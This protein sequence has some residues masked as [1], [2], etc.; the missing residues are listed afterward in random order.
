LQEP[1]RKLKADENTILNGN[2]NAPHRRSLPANTRTLIAEAQ[3][4]NDRALAVL[5]RVQHKLTGSQALCFVSGERGADG[6]FRS[7]L[8]SQCCTYGTSAGRQ[9]HPAGNLFGESMPMFL[10]VV[11][12]LLLARFFA[13]LTPEC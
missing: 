9:T 13:V 1:V 2:A 3:E 5:N 12:F 6:V 4:R 8:Q 7:R 10:W 11:R